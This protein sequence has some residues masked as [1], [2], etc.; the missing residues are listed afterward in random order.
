MLDVTNTLFSEKAKKIKF[1]IFDI[2][3]VFTDGGIFIDD[4]GIEIKAFNILDG[5]GIKLLQ[6][7]PVQVGIISGRNSPSV[8]VRAQQLGIRHVFL[9]H[10]NKLPVY[11][12]LCASQNMNDQEM[13]F[14]GDDLPDLAI[15][16]RVGLPITVP[17]AVSDVKAATPFVTKANGGNGAVREICEAIM[18]AQGTW[19]DVLKK[20][21]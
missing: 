9:G 8:M 5:Q 19:N 21:L 16:K 3:G 2:D 15:L 1:I 13:A 18:R 12:N 17:N 10:L 7:T 6:Q 14:V 4:N 20:Y 11:E